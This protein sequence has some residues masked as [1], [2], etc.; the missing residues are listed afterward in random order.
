MPLRL[1]YLRFEKESHNLWLFLGFNGQ[2]MTC[3]NIRHLLTREREIYKIQ[4]GQELINIIYK[5]T[6]CY[7]LLYIYHTMMK[8]TTF[9]SETEMFDCLYSRAHGHRSITILVV[10]FEVVFFGLFPFGLFDCLRRFKSPLQ[11]AS[12]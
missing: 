1:A 12:H 4:L 2:G 10:G 3:S 8:C 11:V 7:I 6:T 5:D 9:L